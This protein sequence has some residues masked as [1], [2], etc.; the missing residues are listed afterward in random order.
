[1]SRTPY[2]LTLDYYA[3]LFRR[4]ELG[5]LRATLD[6]DVA[7]EMH[8]YARETGQTISEAAREA[9]NLAKHRIRKMPS[10]TTGKLFK[11]RVNLDVEVIREIR[12]YARERGMSSSAAARQAWTLA[13]SEIR[14][15]PPRRRPE[16]PPKGP[17]KKATSGDKGTRFCVNLHGHVWDAIRAYADREGITVSA[18]LRR[19]WLR[20]REQIKSME[21]DA[22]KPA[23]V[24]TKR[25]L[26][27]G[28]KV[29]LWLPGPIVAE[30]EA[31]AAK[32]QGSMS[33]IVRRAWVLARSQ[34]QAM[35]GVR[36]GS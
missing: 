8:A 1:M 35:P 11:V 32:Q 15:L 31:I 5:K 4:S 6:A 28:T 7:Q 10:S 30:V 33:R 29:K 36:D 13:K 20:S 34:I 22:T 21:P 12:A 17:I 16:E 14:E 26:D 23:W 3:K 18:A 2:E 9:W 24:K 19:A 25:P 27:S